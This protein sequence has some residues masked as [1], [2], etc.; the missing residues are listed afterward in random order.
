[1]GEHGVWVVCD[2]AWAGWLAI[3]VYACGH[4]LQLGVSVRTTVSTRC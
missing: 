4:G 1:M 3:L 2:A